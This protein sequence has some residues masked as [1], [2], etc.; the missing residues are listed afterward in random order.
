LKSKQPVTAI[1][2]VDS[3]L[4]RTESLTT[5]LLL[6]TAPFLPKLHPGFTWG[7]YDHLARVAEWL[8]RPQT[9]P[10]S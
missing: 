5:A 1:A 7:E 4:E 6:G 8:D 2:H 9:R 10:G 3:V